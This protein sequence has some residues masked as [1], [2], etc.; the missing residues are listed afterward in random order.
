MSAPAVTRPGVRGR[1]RR[2]ILGAAASVLARDRSATLADIAAAAEVGRST[3]HRYFPDREGLLEA[4]IEDSLQALDQAVAEAALDQ[5]PP[6][7]AMR[8]LVTA[9]VAVGDRILFL[10]GDPRVLEGRQ[11][12]EP[13][14]RP[15]TRL[16]E[17]GQAEGVF[18]PQVGASWIEHVLWALVYSAAEAA[19]NGTLPRPGAT[20]TAI[21][22]FE[23]GIRT[24]GRL[25]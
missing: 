13:S 3:L 14:P 18:D 9:M 7:E 5:G 20:A 23:H 11:D 21:R 24:G 10:F 15:V 12:P 1:T 17:R 6:L 19:A 25:P 16:I 4:V 2:A 8:R 22:T